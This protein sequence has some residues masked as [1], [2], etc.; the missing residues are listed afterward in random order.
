MLGI[1]LH[2]YGF[3]DKAFWALAVF[4]GSQLVFMVFCLIP[5]PFWKPQVAKPASEAAKPA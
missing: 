3:M 2:S 1:G 4:I 5:A